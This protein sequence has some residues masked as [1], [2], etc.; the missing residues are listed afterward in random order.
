[1]TTSPFVAKLTANALQAENPSIRSYV[2]P[3]YLRVDALPSSATRIMQISNS[4]TTVGELYLTTAGKLRLRNNGTTIGA[5]SA[6]LSVGTLY[7][8]G[9]RQK[10]GTGTDAVLEAYLA[11]GAT[12][13]AFGSPF[14][15]NSAQSFTTAATRLTIGATTSSFA[16]AITVDD[17]KLDAGSMPAP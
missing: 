13:F 15:S 8:V 9:L 14:A 1:V 10:Q 11:S 4:G 12:S 5:D 3:V 7:R 6:M 17:I 16:A 2:I